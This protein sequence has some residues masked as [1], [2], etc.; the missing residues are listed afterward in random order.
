MLEKLN[1]KENVILM[2]DFNFRPDTPQYQPTTSAHN[3]AWLISR[4]GDNPSQGTDPPDRIDHLFISHGIKVTDS[5][6]IPDPTSDHPLM[7]TSF[8]ME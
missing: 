3:D 4:L 1:G 2:G 5:R 7:W 8:S 6:Y